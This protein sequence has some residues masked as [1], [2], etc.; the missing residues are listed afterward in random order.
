MG[1]LIDRLNTEMHGEQV[2][3]SD[4]PREA[5]NDRFS[6]YREANDNKDVLEVVFGYADGEGNLMAKDP[7][8][9]E[10]VLSADEF[11]KSIDYYEPSIRDKFLGRPIVT[12]ILRIEETEGR[13]YVQSA[14]NNQRTTRTQLIGELKSE[15]TKGNKPKV[16][17]KVVAVTQKSVTVD[18]FGRGVKGVCP[19]DYWSVNYTRYLK[20]QVKTG[21]LVD[22]E[23][24]EVMPKMR[25]K[26]ICFSLSHAAFTEDLWPKIPEEF[27][28]KGVDIVVKCIDKPE[29]KSYWWGTTELIPGLELQGDYSRKVDVMVSLPYK[30]K[31]DKVDKENHVFKV[32]PFE[33]SEVDTQTAMAVQFIK[34]TRSK[35]KKK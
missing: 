34:E 35:G 1:R 5:E 17:G 19:V 30:C 18:I 3:A 16:V 15:L 24:L 33:L 13:V 11:K 12:T 23:V 31:V 22:F 21:S 7:N 2:K 27:L 6:A 8:G 4:K 29:G 9:V 10:I 25:G 20:E 28:N 26:D 14:R 32:V